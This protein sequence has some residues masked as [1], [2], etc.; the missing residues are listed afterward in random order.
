MILIVDSENTSE[1]KVKDSFKEWGFVSVLVAK[2]AAQARDILSV[3]A[4]REKITLIIIDSMLDDADGFEFCRE[5]I[6]NKWKDDIYIMLLVSSE[7]NKTAID[8]AKHSGANDISVKPYASNVFQKH[9]FKFVNTKAVLL[10]DDDPL[11]RKIVC[12]ILRKNNL[13]VMEVDD[14]VKANNLLNI[15][16]PPKLVI[17]DIGLPHM[18]GIQLVEKIR[19]KPAWKKI[20]IVMLTG[21]SD[22][23]DVKKS[24][25]AGA[26]DYLTKPID[27]VGFSKRIGRYLS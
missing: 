13:E 14:G 26:N 3:D 11:I 24:L 16:M 1:T 9:L 7:D 15:M 12:G 27:I 17:M 22:I 8:K 20:P 5:I 19:S 2:T 25:A 6:K 18:N 23:R 4:R 10:V 21:S